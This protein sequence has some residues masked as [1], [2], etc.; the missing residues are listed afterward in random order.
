MKKIFGALILAAVALT[1]CASLPWSQTVDRS[2]GINQR[3]AKELARRFIRTTQYADDADLK[4][5]KVVNEKHIACLTAHWLVA[6]GDQ[7]PFWALRY[8][9]VVIDKTSGTVAR[10]G[11]N[12]AQ[13]D[14]WS[15]ML[16][17]IDECK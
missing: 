6:I 14:Q 8:Y 7:N 11:V 17:G 10:S 2:D 13:G 16:R 12:W 5:V 1:G 9:Y 4:N 15:P 3:E